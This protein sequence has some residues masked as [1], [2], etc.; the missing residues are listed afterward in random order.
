MQYPQDVTTFSIDDQFLLGEKWGGQLVG[1]WH[2]AKKHLWELCLQMPREG[3]VS[4]AGGARSRRFHVPCSGIP[5]VQ[6]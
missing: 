3:G 4:E 2:W 1:D 5:T 6:S